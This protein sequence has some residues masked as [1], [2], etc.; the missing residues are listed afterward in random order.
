LSLEPTCGIHKPVITS[1][2]GIIPN[3]AALEGKQVDCTVSDIIPNTDLNLLGSDNITL[4][5]TNFP[6]ELDSNTVEISFSDDQ[7]TKC[8]AQS[9]SSTTLV[10]LTSE[11]DKTLSS[12][13]SLTLSIKI[14]ELEVSSTASFT[15]KSEIKSGLSIIPTSVSPV[16]KTKIEIQIDDNFP[17]TLAR[18]DFSVNVTKSD[19]STKMKQLNVVAVDDS[20]KTLTV[21]FGGAY[22]GT[23]LMNIRHKQF[24]LLATDN[25]VLDVSSTV[26]SVSTMTGSINGGTLLTIQGTNF[27]NEITDNPVE[28]SYMD[29][30]G[31]AKCFLESTSP[32]EIKCRIDTSVD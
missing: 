11:F 14:N 13:K 4:S 15:M 16:L 7:A 28:L 23:Y 24:G 6:T 27:G 1:I 20:T 30:I 29:G 26:T 17:F 8:V 9:S 5:G 2:Y 31:S 32:T 22:S 19:D 10:C 25:I 3:D 12:G 18:E 21:M